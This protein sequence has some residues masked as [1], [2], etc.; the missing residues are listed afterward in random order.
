MSFE[1]DLS[2]WSSLDPIYL[3]GKAG[4][5]NLGANVMICYFRWTPV[6]QQNGLIVR[7]RTPALCAIRPMASVSPNGGIAK[8]LAGQ[9]PPPR[10]AVELMN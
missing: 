4:A 5:L 10:S 8:L 9:Q 6:M 3:D 2:A 1:C 7:Q